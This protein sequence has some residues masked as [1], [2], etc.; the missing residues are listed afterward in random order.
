MG[1]AVECESRVLRRNKVIAAARVPVMNKGPL[2]PCSP[3]FHPHTSPFQLS[4]DLGPNR[5]EEFTKAIDGN[6]GRLCQWSSA[7]LAAG[8]TCQR[9]ANI[10]SLAIILS[11]I[12]QVCMIITQ[13]SY[14]PS[15]PGELG[16]CRT[17]PSRAPSISSI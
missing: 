3:L 15:E 5:L 14:I 9:R 16:Y 1:L 4:T 2:L 8:C 7:T 17:I 10:K 12:N 11:L 13:F 6:D